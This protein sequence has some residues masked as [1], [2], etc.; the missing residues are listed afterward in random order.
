MQTDVRGH[1]V[2]GGSCAKESFVL[3]WQLAN[4][5]AILEICENAIGWFDNFAENFVDSRIGQI[6]EEVWASTMSSERQMFV[7][8][9]SLRSTENL[10]RGIYGGLKASILRRGV[11]STNRLFQTPASENS[12]S[13]NSPKSDVNNS[14]SDR[15]SNPS[16]SEGITLNEEAQCAHFC[17]LSPHIG[18][19]GGLR[20]GFLTPHSDILFSLGTT[21]SWE[22]A[23]FWSPLRSLSHV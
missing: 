11:K 19:R 10:V 20:R 15:D 5:L 3:I 12:L 9:D 4:D 17:R 6:V 2:A 18:R 16:Q 21:K 23:T 8:V 13:P 22:D 7:V 1:T 14:T